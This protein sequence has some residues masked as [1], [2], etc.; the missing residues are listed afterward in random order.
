MGQIIWKAQIFLYFRC[1]VLWKHPDSHSRSCKCC[2]RVM[3]DLPECR[4]ERLLECSFFLLLVVGS[5]GAL[6]RLAF[7][8]NKWSIINKCKLFSSCLWKPVTLIPSRCSEVWSKWNFV[9]SLYRLLFDQT[10]P[11]RGRLQKY[12]SPS[13]EMAYRRRIL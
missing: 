7:W 10:W 4:V 11:N 6:G 13:W 5:L 8:E 2:P 1:L 3:K 12:H 9:C